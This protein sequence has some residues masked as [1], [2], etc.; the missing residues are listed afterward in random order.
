MQSRLIDI[1]FR[2]SLGYYELLYKRDR[3]IYSYISQLHVMLWHLLLC[4]LILFVCFTLFSV[5]SRHVIDVTV[6]M[7]YKL[8]DIDDFEP[9]L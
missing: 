4:V 5:I 6:I 8:L 7:I 3:L 2:S 9:L 1:Y